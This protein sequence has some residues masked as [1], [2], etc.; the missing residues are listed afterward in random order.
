MSQVIKIPTLND[1]I[2]DFERL[3]SPHQQAIG[4]DEDLILDFSG[5]N[6]LRHNAVAFI[7][8]LVRTLQHK[9]RSVKINDRRFRDRDSAKSQNALH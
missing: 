6:F 7:G 9:G 5:C 1:R 2:Q 3:F 4:C 8:G